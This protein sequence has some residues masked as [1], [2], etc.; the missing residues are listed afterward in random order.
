M[1]SPLLIPALCLQLA[2]LAGARLL[3]SAAAADNLIPDP[4]FEN[5]QP[6]DRQGRVFPEWDGWVFAE[7]GKFEASAIAHSGATSCEMIAGRGGKIRIFTKKLDAP[8]GRYRLTAW[9]RGLDVI[10]GAYG[11]TADFSVGL[12]EQFHA[13]KDI[14]GTFG[15]RPFTYVFDKP[16]DDPEKKVRIYFGLITAGRLWVDDV[17]LEAVGSDVALTPAPVIGP[18]EKPIVPPTGLDPATAVRCPSCG[19]RN[20]PDASACYACGSEI[21]R[22]SGAGASAP[23]VSVFADFETGQIAPFSSGTIE[24]EKPIDG[25]ASIRIEKAND[26]LALA[27]PLDWSAY[28]YVL[29]DVFNPSDTPKKLSIEVHD[30]GT[31][32]YWTRV[33]FF[34]LAPPGNST[35]R[36]PTRLYVGEKARPGRALQRDSVTK[37]IVG[38]QDDGPLIFDNFRLESLDTSKHVFPGLNAFDFGSPDGPVMEG[39][40]Q[41]SGTM[42]SE[43]RG[44]GW[45]PGAKFWKDQN[46]LQPDALIQDFITPEKATFRVDVPDGKYHVVM[47]IDSPGTYWGEVQRY[48]A[49]SV[50]ANGA[51]VVDETMDYGGFVKKYLAD[52]D[53]EDLPGIDTFA[54]YVQPMQKIQAFD[55]DVKDGKL[56][57]EFS[58]KNWANCL[59]HA[60]I[61]PDSEKARGEEFLAWVDKQRRA[62]FEDYFKQVEPKRTGENPPATGYRL[63]HRSPMEQVNA[64]DGPGPHDKDVA[65]GLLV[66][67]AGGE[68]NP[69]TFSLQPGQDL[70]T[71]TLDLSAFT[72]KSGAKLPE[73]SVTPGWLDYRISRVTMEGSVYSVGPRYWHPLPAPASPGVTRTFWLR[74]HVPEG[75]PAGDYAGNVTVK[76]EKGAPQAF[77]LTVR[78]LPFDLP[79][80]KDLPVGPWGSGI[81]IPWIEG[82]PE[83]EAWDLENF[84]QTLDALKKYGFTSFSGRPHVRVTLDGGKIAIDTSIADNEMRIIR[85]KGFD[86][87]ISTYGIRTVGYNLYL[88]PTQKDADRAGVATPQELA[89]RMFAE[90]DAHAKEKNWVPVA[91]NLC[92]EPIGAQIAPAVATAKIHR[93]A[94]KGLERTTFMGATSMTGNDPADPHYELVRAL[95]LPSLTLFDEASLGVIKDAGNAFGYYNGGNRWTFGF[96]MKMLKDRHALALRLNWHFNVAAGNPYYALDCREDDYCWFNTNE[97]REMVPSLLFLQEM[98]PGLNDYRRLLELDS[99]LALAKKALAA[100]PSAAAKQ[101]L[102]TAIAA[103][104]KVTAKVDSLRAGRE[105]AKPPDDVDAERA[106]L[107][108]AIVALIEAGAK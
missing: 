68:E 103:G 15:W 104:E 50:K 54:R 67:V 53:A 89:N 12:T 19:Y 22:A 90:I 7:P 44:Y 60:V 43:G 82:D 9:L 108:A 14:S 21:A 93:E 42:Y 17:C 97:R 72:A 74:V 101:A 99:R 29:F 25:T 30:K 3:P 105:G 79:Q 64:F 35:V 47:N 5:A 26:Y 81:G 31:K 73:G 18:E 71:V 57:L 11:V 102:E 32:G 75:T 34:N 69:A 4:S 84:S 38:L 27:K 87:T 96:Y 56:D 78:V 66:D 55:V 24:A 61:F 39:F 41:E 85:E 91:Y 95:L 88:G 28:D 20:L 49:R 2:F 58:G 45:L 13:L 16:A 8:P 98:V 77:P 86:Q 36:F 92:D 100:S 46:A 94:A 6:V 59:T 33:N 48:E 76:P 80:V 37:F 40:S 62:Q 65:G 51:T 63:F 52:A 70:G 107:T 106:E 23:P 1:K 83:V 10:P